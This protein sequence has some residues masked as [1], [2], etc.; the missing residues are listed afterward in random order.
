MF[1][2]ARRWLFH[3]HKQPVSPAMASWL[4]VAGQYSAIDAD[5]AADPGMCRL[6]LS[7]PTAH[8]TRMLEEM[9]ETIADD[10]SETRT[11]ETVLVGR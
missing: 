3:R 1:N 2:R 6:T 8:I 11:M 5:I 4:V 7:K 10:L 9:D